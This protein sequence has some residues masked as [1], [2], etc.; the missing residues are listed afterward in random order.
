MILSSPSSSHCP[1]CV[2]AFSA[3]KAYS[4][5]V[6]P[7]TAQTE[8][9]VPRQLE[10]SVNGYGPV[11]LALSSAFGAIGAQSRRRAARST[12]VVL[13]ESGRGRGGQTPC[14]FAGVELS[15]A[16]A[17]WLMEQQRAC[18]GQLEP[19][20]IQDKCMKRIFE[21][22][23]VALQAPTGTG[24]TLA[25][26]LPLWQRWKLDKLASM[27]PDGP[28]VLV[29][30][31][32]EDLQM[33]IGGVARALMGAG[34]EDAV[35][36]LRRNVDSLEQRFER[37]AIV[38]AT[39]ATLLDTIDVPAFEQQW[40]RICAKLSA[41]VLDE[42][43]GLLPM[44][45]AKDWSVGNVLDSILDVKDQMEDRGQDSDLQIVAASASIDIRTL[46]LLAEST[47]IPMDLVRTTA[48]MEEDF[49]YE[50]LEGRELRDSALVEGGTASEDLFP[51]GLRHLLM[52]QERVMTPTGD[53]HKER[54]MPIAAEAIRSFSPKKCIVI[55]GERRPTS[56][57]GDSVGK[58]MKR[59]RKELAYDGYNVS[60]ISAMVEAVAGATPSMNASSQEREDEDAPRE[61]YIG[62]G[63]SVRGLDIPQVGMVIIIGELSSVREYMHLAGR[64]ARHTPGS[65]G[66]PKG[67]VLSIISSKSQGMLKR[68]ASEMNFP[69]GR[70]MMG[71]N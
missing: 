18:K 20:A 50:P 29:L 6:V 43:D 1:G 61:V 55:L 19:T 11:A 58:Y 12:R 60:S 22:E 51:T 67:T 17:A 3:A 59:L 41:V 13:G 47:G 68:W 52:I 39:P 10:N 26:L 23:S 46:T 28:R 54:M 9:G 7:V 16:A 49:E 66:V 8:N 53:V 65:K 71:G 37:A 14:E 62:R 57:R 4:K 33:Q 56:E 5:A 30:T 36:V 24:K 40:A 70:Y 64:T 45:G 34:R 69:I 25:F 38:V 31:P 48:Q 35:L 2:L 15:G 63:E 21:G 42:A 32:S 44:G 27:K